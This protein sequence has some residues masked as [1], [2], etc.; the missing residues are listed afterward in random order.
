MF[1]TFALFCTGVVGITETVNRLFKVDGKTAKFVVSWVVSIG[2]ACLGFVL[3]YG[4]FADLG[5]PAEWQGWVKAVFIGVFCAVCSNRT[6]DMNEI[7]RVLQIIFSFFDKD[8]KAFRKAM[9]EESKAKRE[10]LTKK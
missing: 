7:W 3:Q 5:A 8:G 2:M 9:R 10:A 4:I 6:Y 1:A